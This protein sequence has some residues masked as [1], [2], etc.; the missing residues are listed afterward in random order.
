MKVI[1]RCLLTYLSIAAVTL[2]AP[3]R[4]L[5]QTDDSSAGRELAQ[6]L[7]KL[8]PERG[9]QLA[10]TLEDAEVA[11]L[12]AAEMKAPGAPSREALSAFAQRGGGLVVLHGAVAS[13]DPAWWK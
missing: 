7:E 2:A 10:K 9:A 4:V 1:A 5:I 12:F 13:A 8:L 11:V 3:V 6:R